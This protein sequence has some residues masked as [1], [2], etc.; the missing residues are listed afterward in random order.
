MSDLVLLRCHR[1]AALCRDRLAL[2]RA[3]APR[4]ALHALFGGAD[5]DFAAF[6][7]E[8]GDA[9]EGCTSVPRRAL[10][11]KWLHGDLALAAWFRGHGHNLAFDR[12]IFWEWDLLGLAPLAE[13]YRAIPPAAVGLTGLAPLAEV[14]ARWS[15]SRS[16][17]WRRG[18]SELRAKLAADHGF[19]G[20]WWASQGPGPCLPRSFLERFAELDPPALA[21][22][23]VR[24]PAYAAALGFPLADNG[25]L[26]AW[27]DPGEA[28]LFNCDGTEIAP[29]AIAAELA[30][31]S[32]RRVFHPVR[33]AFPWRGHLA[34]SVPFEGAIA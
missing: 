28:T 7:A 10:R 2:L 19:S 27:A 13:L 26:R 18:W 1:D 32:G 25:W 31:P 17:A 6:R 30:R 33:S 8:L 23:E 24:L 11:W 9:V 12:L 29:A 22:D 15:W 16:T 5:E 3:L 34:A 21:H 20:P 14:E 4:C